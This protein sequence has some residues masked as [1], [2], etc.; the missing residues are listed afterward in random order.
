MLA[1]CPDCRR[2]LRWTYVLYMSA[3]QWQCEGCGSLLEFDG[4]RRMLTVALSLPAVAAMAY[5]VPSVGLGGLAI[6]GVI[7]GVQCCFFLL[8][9]QSVVFERCELHCYGC[10]YD[11]RGQVAQRCPECGAAMDDTQRQ[12]LE[13]GRFD[14][15]VI[16]RRRTVSLG[17]VVFL[18]AS[19]VTASSLILLTLYQWLAYGR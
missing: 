14:L 16:R 8:L 5:N 11:L 19:G 3:S 17:F 6:I 10:G 1:E 15:V 18:I 12:I 2:R 7:L 9:D 4:R 13:T